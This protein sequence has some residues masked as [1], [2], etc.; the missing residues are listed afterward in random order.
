MLEVEFVEVAAV[1]AVLSFPEL[2]SKDIDIGVDESHGASYFG[3][4]K[5]SDIGYLLPGGGF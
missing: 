3:L 2:S 5:A 1:L 4:K